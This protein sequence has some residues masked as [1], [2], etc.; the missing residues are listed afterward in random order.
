[1]L[2][3][4]RTHARRKRQLTALSL[5][6]RPPQVLGKKFDH[7]GFQTL[8]MFIG[9]SLMLLY[10]LGHQY[11]AAAGPRA[12]AARTV[13]SVGSRP[14]ASKAS[15]PRERDEEDPLRAPLLLAV[16]R[17]EGGARSVPLRGPLIA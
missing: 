11:W 10:F 17:G 2:P 4:L 13:T 7:P 14:S 5:L 15:S 16:G 9:E 8:I 1:M 3:I 12:A 6:H